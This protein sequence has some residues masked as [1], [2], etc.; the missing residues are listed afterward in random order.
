[1]EKPKFWE[2][3]KKELIKK[4]KKL[5]KIIKNYKSDF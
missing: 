3:A 5:G 2:K 1:M 4:D